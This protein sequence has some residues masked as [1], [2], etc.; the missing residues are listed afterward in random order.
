MSLIAAN[1]WLN[2]CP[3]KRF[4]YLCVFFNNKKRCKWSTG[5]SFLRLDSEVKLHNKLT[6]KLNIWMWPLENSWARIR[7][8]TATS[9]LFIKPI[10]SQITAKWNTAEVKHPDSTKCDVKTRQTQELLG[11]LAIWSAQRRQAG[12]HTASRMSLRQMDT[13]PAASRDN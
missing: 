3:A 2:L 8:Q 5:W 10:T 11:K 6:T 1:K 9:S 12:K 13:M 4:S 7:H